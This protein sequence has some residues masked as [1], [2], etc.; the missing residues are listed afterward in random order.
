MIPSPSY[1]HLLVVD[2][3]TGDGPRGTFAN[4][5]P[6]GPSH[7]TILSQPFRN[8]A[9]IPNSCFIVFWRKIMPLLRMANAK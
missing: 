3:A 6:I 4:A 8:D 7:G 2:K 1:E 5:L 9:N